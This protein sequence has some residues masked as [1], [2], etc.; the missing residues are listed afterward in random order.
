MRMLNLYSVRS[1]FWN[2]LIFL[3]IFAAKSLNTEIYDCKVQ[4][5]KAQKHLN[6][7][8]GSLLRQ[9]RAPGRDRPRRSLS[10]HEYA[11]HPLL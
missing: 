10:A 3:P 2:L 7:Q 4:N 9:S 11:Q 1:D 6:R 5:R 8:K